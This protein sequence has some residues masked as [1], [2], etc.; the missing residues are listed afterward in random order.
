LA[1]YEQELA[2]QAN[3]EYAA[4]DFAEIM[5]QMDEPGASPADKPCRSK[6][7]ASRSKVVS[8]GAVGKNLHGSGG[9]TEG[10][11]QKRSYMVSKAANSGSDS[12]DRHLEVGRD[13]AYQEDVCDPLLEKVVCELLRMR[14]MVSQI[15]ECVRQEVER[16]EA[17][18]ALRQAQTQLKDAEDE[19]RRASEA[20]CG[21]R[22]EENGHIKAAEK[23]RADQEVQRT[24]MLQLVAEADDLVH[25]EEEGAMLRRI[26]AI[27][28]KGDEAR[29]ALAVLDHIP[30]LTKAT[31]EHKV[32][33]D[34]L[35]KVKQ[36]G[37]TG[38]TLMDAFQGFAEQAARSE[39]ARAEA[40]ARALRA[41]KE[42]TRLKERY[43][44]LEEA[45]AHHKLKSNTCT[46]PMPRLTEWILARRTQG[47]VT[48]SKDHFGKLTQQKVIQKL[49]PKALDLKERAV[50]ISE[51][52]GRLKEEEQEYSSKV[53]EMSERS[54]SLLQERCQALQHARDVLLLLG[55]AEQ[56]C[57]EGDTERHG[58]CD[59]GSSSGAAVASCD[60]AP[61]ADGQSERRDVETEGVDGQEGETED[62]ELDRVF[63]RLKQ[64][65]FLSRVRAYSLP[66]AGNDDGVSVC[67]LVSER[68]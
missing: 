57:E 3:Q 65:S 32:Y 51:Q 6:R 23:A 60:R 29:S 17:I 13:N 9:K 10:Q 22:C 42:H 37:D 56:E 28:K 55:E 58:C 50:N 31:T 26:E 1:T 68:R 49:K 38:A 36:R 67:A 45:V 16:C 39:K 8:L 44:Q 25:G 2:N 7:S 24:K 41:E 53:K 30:A 21:A 61:P 66:F 40:S 27:I 48:M 11:T 20:A 35:H 52:L 4:S 64:A 46:T 54:G 62:G 34:N 43:T 12:K 59:G 19:V 14:R 5:D 33:E 18:A 15:P 47:G 63:A